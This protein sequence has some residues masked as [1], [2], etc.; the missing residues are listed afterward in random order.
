MRM[1]L[2]DGFPHLHKTNETKTGLIG[3]TLYDVIALGSD[4]VVTFATRR[5]ASDARKA[6]QWDAISDTELKIPRAESDSRYIII[7]E[8]HYGECQNIK[9]KK[10]SLDGYPLETLFFRY[11]ELQNET[12]EGVKSYD[13]RRRDRLFDNFNARIGA[14]ALAP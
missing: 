8:P 5:A 13:Q 9:K 14:T 1:I 11:F 10:I 4:D 2:R 3:P 6:T 12:L 7:W